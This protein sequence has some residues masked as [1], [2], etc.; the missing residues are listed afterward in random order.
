MTAGGI[1]LGRDGEL[2]RLSA[3]LDEAR[4]GRGGLYLLAGEP[5]IG[6]TRLAHELG[7][8]AADFA[9]HW[10]RCWE[11]GGAPAYW[12]WTQILGALLR[13]RTPEA[14][15]A[16]TGETGEAL[17]SIIPELAQP[18]AVMAGDAQEARFQIFRAVVGL[19]GRLGRERPL[20]LVLDDLHAA[21]Q[22]SLL[23]LHF[24]ARE[25][26]GLRALII[27]TY[28]DVEARLSAEVGQLLARTGREAQILNLRRLGSEEVASYVRQAAQHVSGE[29]VDSIF[30]ATQ[31]NPLFLDE[32]VRALVAGGGS[33]EV[34]FPF[35]VRE[36]IRQHL[37]LLSEGVRQHLEVA[38][39]IGHEPDVATVALAGGARG[40]EVEA[41]LESAAGAGVLLARGRQRFAFSHGL[42]REALYRDLPN[43]RRMQL[44]RAV[45][46]TLDRRE[47]SSKPWPQLAH[48]YLE[49]GP[50]VVGA[51]VRCSIR[52]AESAL[53]A[54]AYE[55]ATSILERA[56]VAAELAPADPADCAELTLAEGMARMRA[57]DARRG[58]ELCAQAAEQARRLPDP[59]L[60]ARAALGYGS[61]FT[62]GLTDP[63]LVRLL[64]EAL[65]GLPAEDSVLRARAM[66]R[67]ASAVQPAADPAPPMQAARDAIAMARRIGDPATLLAV[68]HSGMSALMDF[69]AGSERMVLNLEAERLALELGDRPRALRA[70]A[71]LMFDYLEA[72][73][74]DRADQCLAGY[75]DLARA[76]KVRRAIWVVPIFRSMRAAMEGRFADSAA[77]VAE[78]MAL[79]EEAGDP[80]RHWILTSHQLGLAR[81]RERHEELLALDPELRAAFGESPSAECWYLV[82]T[83]SS[84]ARMG[85]GEE[86]AR[87]LSQMPLDRMLALADRSSLGFLAEAV[88]G[89]GDRAMAAAVYPALAPLAGNLLGSG[90]M[91]AFCEGPF[92]RQ[93]GLLAAT[94][95]R[96]GEAV[97]HFQAAATQ[98]RALNL[99]PHLARILFELAQALP[100]DEAAQARSL[101]GE[102]RALAAELELTGLLPQIEAAAH[103]LSGAPAR[104]PPA[105]FEPPPFELSREGDY[106][107]LTAG[108]TVLRLKDSRG[109][110]I[111]HRLISHPD[112]EFHATDLA[113]AGEGVADAGDA[114]EM[115]DHEA[116]ESYRRRVDDLQEELREAE[117]FQDAGRAG[118]AREELDFIAG[119][120]SRAVGLGGRDRRAGAAAERARVAVQKRLKEAIR[121]VEEGAPALGRHLTLTVRTGTFCAYHPSGRR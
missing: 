87:R 8:R 6:K 112:Q 75:D 97:R 27:G 46:E 81:A 85:R 118:R 65:A 119:E 84:L 89:T 58:G 36:A 18:R 23:L 108:E 43:S 54:L 80:S 63:T 38:A 41:A 83:G 49:A 69:V 121:K 78:A 62:F 102:A 88:A 20:L 100:P 82:A 31:G 15:R 10:G 98:A 106:W 34:G 77:A 22:S 50:A 68:I 64:E 91:G 90:M 55:D 3:G 51:A 60:F 45:A 99:R 110:Q 59:L 61:E 56:R 39:V 66:A 79:G 94:L 11:S 72:G 116:R 7:A 28:R 1:F 2:G 101:L 29:T 17:G 35:G 103:R 73:A 76:L 95:G 12:P 19:L 42:V 24:V 86:A 111:L 47:G 33:E 109:L 32:V 115:L 25:L 113:V 30:R 93:L 48:H 9:V 57:G 26:R 5:G 4:A 44:H 21:D 13:D 52:A 14:V 114:G 120:L 70:R 117:S 92:D 53:D 40:P 107:S 96:T 74:L 71:R 16:I 104:R 67:L 105:A 37:A